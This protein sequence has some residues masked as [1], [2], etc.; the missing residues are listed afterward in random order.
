MN[1][2]VD[3]SVWFLAL[4]RRPADLSAAEKAIVVE[5]SELVG[6]GRAHLIGLVRQELLSG[7]RAPAQCE[8]LRAALAAFLDE[9]VETS[10]Y[11]AAAKASNECRAN[12]IVVSV[13]D[14][15]ICT[16]ALNR[17]WS[18]FTIDPDFRHYAKVLPVKL[19]SPRR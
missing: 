8:K 15:L 14:I 5:L 13:V 1:V 4:R 19:H 11:E 18:I 17:S 16:V 3:T 12:G 10:D 6:E 9:P 7:I 2:L